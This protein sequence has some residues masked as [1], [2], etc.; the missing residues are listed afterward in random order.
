MLEQP[1]DNKECEHDRTE[2]ETGPVSALRNAVARA[3][4]DGLEEEEGPAE[5][6]GEKVD[7]SM[8][9]AGDKLEEAADEV[10]Q[11]TD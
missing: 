5:K 7:E 3:G 4:P 2:V 6:L 11:R 1:S 10:E 8:E 9:Q